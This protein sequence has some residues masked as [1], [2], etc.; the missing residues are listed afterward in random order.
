MN[1]KGMQ[2]KWRTFTMTLAMQRRGELFRGYSDFVLYL[3]ARTLRFAGGPQV[4]VRVEKLGGHAVACRIG[5]SDIGP[6]DDL[7]LHQYSLLSKT[8][9]HEAAA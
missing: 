8:A 6:L 9:G 7:L 1:A 4:R 3:L 2:R 5:T